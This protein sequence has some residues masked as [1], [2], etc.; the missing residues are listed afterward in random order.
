MPEVTPLVNWDGAR[1]LSH[2]HCTPEPMLLNAWLFSPSKTLHLTNSFPLNCF[3]PIK[4]KKREIETKQKALLLLWNT[5][6]LPE[7]LR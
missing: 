4:K 1:I 7:L 2:P 5:E 6:A 3:P